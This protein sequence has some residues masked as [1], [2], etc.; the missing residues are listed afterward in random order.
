[1]NMKRIFQNFISTIEDPVKLG[2]GL[3]VLLL[4]GMMILAGYLF[5]NTL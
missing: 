3:V 5:S 2:L 4:V 1:M